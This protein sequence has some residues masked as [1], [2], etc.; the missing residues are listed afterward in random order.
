MLETLVLKKTGFYYNFFFFLTAAA[1]H[2]SDDEIRE[3][4][5]NGC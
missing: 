1:L 2:G 3:L 5:N 4:R